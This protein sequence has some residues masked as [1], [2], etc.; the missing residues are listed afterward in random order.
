MIDAINSL[1]LSMRMLKT[2]LCLPSINDKNIQAKV[3][4]GRVNMS[5]LNIQSNLREQC[6]KL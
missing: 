4:F 5:F 3:I 1:G 6:S 2:H